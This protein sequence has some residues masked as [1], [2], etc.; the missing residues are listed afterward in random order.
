MTPRRY[1]KPV[2]QT[3]DGLPD[4]CTWTVVS[5]N[6]SSTIAADNDVVRD[7]IAERATA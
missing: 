7:A 3:A 4:P 6:S 5:T 2:D 1:V